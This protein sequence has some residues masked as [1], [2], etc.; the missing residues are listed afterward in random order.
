MSN[1]VESVFKELHRSGAIR[2]VSVVYMDWRVMICFVKGDGEEGTI[3]SKRGGT[4]LYRLE[5]ALNFLHECGLG[6]V[7]VDFRNLKASGQLPL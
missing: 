3:N 4:K 7:Q 1:L 5:T 6:V 2:S